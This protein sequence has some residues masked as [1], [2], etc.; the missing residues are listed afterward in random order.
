MLAGVFG[1][2]ESAEQSVIQH[3][4]TSG[5]RKASETALVDEI[6]NIR[7]ERRRI[8]SDLMTVCESLRSQSKHIEKQLAMAREDVIDSKKVAATQLEEFRQVKDQELQT[9]IDALKKKHELKLKE[10][11]ARLDDLI[12]T[13]GVHDESLIQKAAARLTETELAKQKAAF[14][15]N[16]LR[17]KLALKEI[18]EREKSTEAMISRQAKLHQ[19]NVDEIKSLRAQLHNQS[20][21]YATST[22]TVAD[23]QAELERCKTE[24]LEQRTLSMSLHMELQRKEERA[25]SDARDLSAKHAL[26]LAAIDEK[27]RLALA[28]KDDIIHHLHQSN[29]ALLQEQSELKA[30]LQSVFRSS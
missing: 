3:L 27:V 13:K 2:I 26:E 28:K 15:A 24:L 21:S 1:S 29:V 19:E 16:L 6:L 10:V 23:V 7:R 18:L 4:R 25:V 9:Q 5:L 30:G 11:G 22:K 8:F 14:D 20:Q 17:Y 12:S